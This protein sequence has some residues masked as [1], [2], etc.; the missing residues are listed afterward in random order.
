MSQVGNLARTQGNPLLFMTSAMGF[1]MTTESQDLSLKSHP[2][3]GISCSTMSPSLHW[4]KGI[5]FLA[6]WKVA[7]C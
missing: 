7:P 4:G 5:D 6:K 3:D 1:F 2:K